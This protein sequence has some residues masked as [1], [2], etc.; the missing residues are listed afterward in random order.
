MPKETTTEVPSAESAE[1]EI[2]S[3]QVVLEGNR[4]SG[5]ELAAAFA[6]SR[7]AQRD[8]SAPTEEPGQE[9]PESAELESETPPDET[10]D[11]PE[12]SDAASAPDSEVEAEEEAAPEDQEPR[13]FREMKARIDKVTA[14]KKELERELADL[15]EKLD[16]TPTQAPVATAQNNFWDH[17]AEVKDL[18]HQIEGYK[19]MQKWLAE[20]PEGGELTDSKGNV[21]QVIDA[22]MAEQLRQ[23][24]AEKLPELRAERSVRVRELKAMD[25]QLRKQNEQ[26][27][28]KR[29][30][31]ANDPKS[32][33]MQFIRQVTQVNPGITVMPGWQLYA[34]HAIEGILRDQAGL[35]KGNGG[36]AAAPP[37]V[38]VP[39]GATAPRVAPL[40]KQLAEAQAAY[41]K[42]GRESDFKRVQV[43]RRQMRQRQA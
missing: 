32:P 38:S 6:R 29:F 10:T 8:E 34:G 14:Q 19:G 39:A 24:A 43:L 13:G 2:P 20:N 25:A 22:E 3:G 18:S 17:D 31:W 7:K 40:Q 5:A 1:Q 12:V 37:R 21:T 15:K 28:Q 35:A 30:T 41:E 11:S 9:Q 33:Q 23:D 26:A 4:M 42:T 27:F 16:Q 36:R